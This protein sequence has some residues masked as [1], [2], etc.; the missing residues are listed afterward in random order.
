MGFVSITEFHGLCPA[1]PCCGT[2]D[3]LVFEE[4]V[5]ALITLTGGSRASSP[6]EAGITAIDMSRLRIMSIVYDTKHPLGMVIHS[7]NSLPKKK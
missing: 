7:I 6:F 3:K 1:T 4:Y 5:A 2:L